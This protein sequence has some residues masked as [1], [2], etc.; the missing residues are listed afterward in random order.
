M[1]VLMEAILT[2]Q[3][4]TEQLEPL[5]GGKPSSTN[6]GCRCWKLSAVFMLFSQVCKE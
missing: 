6:S 5:T 3:T 1:C 2:L 4:E